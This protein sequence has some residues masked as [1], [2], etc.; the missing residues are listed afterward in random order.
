MDDS[1]M[2]TAMASIFQ[3]KCEREDIDSESYIDDRWFDV[4]FISNNTQ[5]RYDLFVSS[6][7]VPENILNEQKLYIAPKV[8]SKYPSTVY[9]QGSFQSQLI[10]LVSPDEKIG[11]KAVLI[12]ERQLEMDKLYRDGE[13]YLSR[14]LSMQDFSINT[15][16]R[17]RV[18]ANLLLL[19][20]RYD[21][22]ELYL[23]KCCFFCKNGEIASLESVDNVGIREMKTYITPKVCLVWNPVNITIEKRF[24]SQLIYQLV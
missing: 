16:R 10:Y 20:E 22:N 1:N 15:L 17:Y 4:R 14:E 6:I 18:L 12:N 23:E 7:F 11:Y 5:R 24:R 13:D 9:Q 8:L 19:D 2:Y 21:G 3:E